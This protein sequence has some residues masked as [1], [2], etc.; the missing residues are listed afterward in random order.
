M[1][2]IED[3]LPKSSQLRSELIE[4]KSEFEGIATEVQTRIEDSQKFINESRTQ[5]IEVSQ[6]EL[7]IAKEQEQTE[8]LDYLNEQLPKLIEDL[9]VVNELT[10]MTAEVINQDHLK[11]VRIDETISLSQDCMIHGNAE[12]ER[13]EKYQK[14]TCQ[15]Y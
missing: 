7:L 10:R 1:T 14:K 8:E 2:G 5:S 6:E 3:R 12:L 9:R 11:I 13:A 15:I 4:L